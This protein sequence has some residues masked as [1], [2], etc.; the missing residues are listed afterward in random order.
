MLMLLLLLAAAAMR[1]LL[2]LNAHGS[3]VLNGHGSRS[4]QSSQVLSQH[5]VTTHLLLLLLLSWQQQ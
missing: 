1:P 3:S 2:L 5:G 4:F